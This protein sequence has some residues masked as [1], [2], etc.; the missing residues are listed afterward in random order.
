M[1]D[2][3]RR[4]WVSNTKTK[5]TFKYLIYKEDIETETVEKRYSKIN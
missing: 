2:K 4:E 5:E 1:T 3:K